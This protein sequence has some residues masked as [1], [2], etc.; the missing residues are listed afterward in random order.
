MSGMNDRDDDSSP[1]DDRL[2]ENALPG[3]RPRVSE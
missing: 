3:C 2:V 1:A